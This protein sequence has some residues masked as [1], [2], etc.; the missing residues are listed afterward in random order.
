[1]RVPAIT[2][3]WP[4]QLEVFR[5]TGTAKFAPARALRCCILL[6]S[7]V[8]TLR[9]LAQ[10]VQPDLRSTSS[11]SSSPS[12]LTGEDN[13]EK[14]EKSDNQKDEPSRRGSLVGAPIPTSS[15]AIGTGVTLMGGYIFS[16]NKDDKLSPP[17]VI[18]GTG[19]LTNNGTRAWAIGTELYFN[20]D[21]YHVLTGFAHADLNY[22]F[23]GTGTAS[24]SA[25]VKLGLN[26]TGNVFFGEA[27]R[28]V[29]WRM[30][31]GPRL[32]FGTSTIVPQHL[33]E[34]RPDLP[35]LG[36]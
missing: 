26:Q 29:F 18:G 4:R 36:V 32:W 13:K 16:I 11:S 27:L 2:N 21:H 28:R 14:S 24:G 33:G 23:Y 35:P 12:E 10:Q 1:M 25:G 9:S 20:Q 34:S 31:V 17:S 22:D 19:I 30:F 3:H 7:F 15:A 6:I 5:Q 8:L